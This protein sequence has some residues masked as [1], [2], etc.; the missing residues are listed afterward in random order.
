MKSDEL[1]Y[2]ILNEIFTMIFVN[3]RKKIDNNIYNNRMNIIID[4]NC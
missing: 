1:Y 2:N 3:K 4:E